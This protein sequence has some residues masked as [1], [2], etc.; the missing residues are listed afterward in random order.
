MELDSQDQPINVHPF[1][2]LALKTAKVDTI[3]EQQKMNILDNGDS[4][5]SPTPNQPNMNSGSQSLYKSD[6]VVV[7]EEQDRSIHVVIPQSRHRTEE[8]GFKLPPIKK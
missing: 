4:R 1:N 5:N 8:G 7:S 6:R 2:L 3:I